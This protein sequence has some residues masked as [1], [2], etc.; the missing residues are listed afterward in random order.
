M[1]SAGNDGRPSFLV[2]GTEVPSGYSVLV[3]GAPGAGK[4]SIARSSFREAIAATN[5]GILVA[6][7][8]QRRW[9]PETPVSDDCKVLRLDGYSWKA[10][11]ASGKYS[12]RNLSNLNDLSIKMMEAADEVGQDFFYTV[13][14][15]SDLAVYCKEEDILRF[16]DV[17]LAYYRARCGTGIWVVEEGIHTN[18]FNNMLK[19]LTDAVLELKLD[20]QEENLDRRMR[21]AILRGPSAPARW[22]RF[23]ILGDGQVVSGGHALSSNVDAPPHPTADNTSD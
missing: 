6:L 10:G 7:E 14:S 18:S 20:E 19:H 4:T 21:W 15:L 2:M 5:K 16:V 22:V 23:S 8:P 12:V 11:M 13:D 1:A 3:T 17:V 9:G